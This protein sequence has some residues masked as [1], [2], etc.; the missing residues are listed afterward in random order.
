MHRHLLETGQEYEMHFLPDPV[1]WTEVPESLAVLGSQ[2][3]RWQ[4]GLI[5]SLMLHRKMFFNPKYGTIGMI[6]VPYFLIFE[7]FAPIFEFAGIVLVIISFALGYINLPFFGLFLA[8]VILFGSVLTTGAVLMEAISFRRYPKA[9]E[10]LRMVAAG[11]A[12]RMWWRV[13]GYR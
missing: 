10:L 11:F 1:C 9:T 6:G 7:M 4:R 12:A 2:R 5:E 8:V 3:N 13:I